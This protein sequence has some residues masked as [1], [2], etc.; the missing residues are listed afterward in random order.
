MVMLAAATPPTPAPPG[1]AALAEVEPLPDWTAP[2]WR[3]WLEPGF[4]PLPRSV[5]ADWLLPALHRSAV[6]LPDRRAALLRV[7]GEVSAASSDYSGAETDLKAAL[8]AATSPAERA[9]TALA[10]ARVEMITDPSAAEVALAGTAGE[11]RALPAAQLYRARIALARGDEAGARRALQASMAAA[12][13][14]GGEVATVVARAVFADL[15]LLN[16]GNADAGAPWLGIIGHGAAANPAPIKRVIPMCDPVGGLSEADAVIFE[17]G[18]YG[19]R[20][21]RVQPVW[22]ARPGATRAVAALG[23]AVLA[24]RWPADSDALNHGVRVYLS[25]SYAG[26][27]PGYEPNEGPN[28]WLVS[29]R[30][31]PLF[32]AARTSEARQSALQTELA[33][34]MA[35]DGPAAL[36]LVPLLLQTAAEGE[37]SAPLRQGARERALAILTAQEAPAEVLLAM[38]LQIL[39]NGE[40][41]DLTNEQLALT[42]VSRLPGMLATIP[43]AARTTPT[44]LAARG[45][46]AASAQ[47]L[48][49][50]DRAR[51]EWTAVIAGAEADP[52]LQPL[53]TGARLRLAD[54][55]DAEGKQAEAD[56]LRRAAGLTRPLCRF[57]DTQPGIGS[58]SLTADDYPLAARKAL[59]EGLVSVE[60]QVAADGSHIAPRIV[61]AFPPRL[62]D[63]ATLKPV[64]ASRSDPP[65]RAGLSYPCTANPAT[66]RWRL[67]ND[68]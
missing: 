49:D 2:G 50:R 3:D 27:L 66:V 12:I 53:L 23:R 61:F 11:P 14:I 35:A 26:D 34:R 65:R 16:G 54:L 33:R 60:R 62:F 15:A 47:S 25:C 63:A 39:L 55:A 19:G 20:P 6:L 40:T 41:A 7:A 38:Q 45:L 48:G 24:F 52:R 64:L 51:T 5:S 56:G 68:N 59:V 36:S 8:A 58:L 9:A 21:W 37:T 46:L 42:L 28:K 67:E 1:Q 13:D 17:V 31:Y 18:G 57:A 43:A 29:Q 22:M 30:L 10:L 44:V 4:E 32:T